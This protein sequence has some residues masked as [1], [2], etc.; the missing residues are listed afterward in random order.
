MVEKVHFNMGYKVEKV[1]FDLLNL[2]PHA[3]HTELEA[4]M[5]YN[6]KKCISIY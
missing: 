6:L 4:E 1:N 5:G 3:Q 2:S